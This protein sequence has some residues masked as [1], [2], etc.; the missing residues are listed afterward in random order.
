MR[1][2]P[3]HLLDIVTEFGAGLPFKPASYG[4]AYHTVAETVIADP[5]VRI[6]FVVDAD[7]ICSPCK[8]LVDGRC[9]DVLTQLD[10]PMSKLEYNDNVDR[11]LLEYLGMAEGV[12]MTFREYLQIVREHLDGIEMI[13]KHPGEEPGKRRAHLAAG[14]RK[15]G[16]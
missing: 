11:R 9:D 6:E 2:R 3:H 7:D 12:V 15:L 13:C 5:D 16:A 1:I 14:L 8:H 4:H 10:P